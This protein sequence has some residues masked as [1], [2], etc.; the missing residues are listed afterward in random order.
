MGFLSGRAAFLRFKVSGSAPREFT[1]DHLDLLDRNSAMRSKIGSADGT[2][3]GWVGGDHIL[4][5][6]FTDEKNLAADAMVFGMKL[7]TN[8]LPGELL[9]AY[10]ANGLRDRAR[11]NE[12]GVAS[13][14]QKKEAKEEAKEKLED[15]AKDGR[16]IKRKAIPVLWDRLS[17]EV[18]FGSPTLAHVDRM[19]N[20]FEKTFERQLQCVT[21]GPRSFHL[22]EVRGQTR[23][24]DD[25]KPSAFVPGASKDIAWIA[26]ES[27][28]DFLGNEFL[29]WLWYFAETK[30][31]T[32]KVLDD[33]EIT[34]MLARSLSLDC[35]RGQTGHVDVAHEGPSRQGE[36]R[37]AIRSGKLP[38]KVGLTMVRNDQQY[39]LTLAAETLGVSAAK[40]PPASEE[41]LAGGSRV[42]LEERISRLR[43]LIET[44]D[45]LYDAFG[46]IRFGREWEAELKGMQQ[47]LK[48]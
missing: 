1:E 48:K 17:N 46:K 31:D 10:Y 18:L 41:A 11:R 7:E 39:E 35:P 42:L 30:S 36:A 16:F 44:L 21:A 43:D 37:Y 20:L 2:S 23:A 34:F 29:A 6:H 28:R 26:D 33:S 32:I 14:K 9:H 19:C 38:R 27:S 15:E 5:V 24:V 22:A 47:W 45:L 13:A 25:S 3:I 8:K 12:S 40:L 4:D